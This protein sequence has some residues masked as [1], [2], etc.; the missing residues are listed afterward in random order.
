[1]AI[2]DVN[3][4]GVSSITARRRNWVLA[5]LFAV[6]ALNLFDRQIINVLAQDI[7]A[8]LGISDTQLGLLTGTAFGIFYSVLALPLGRLADRV[9]RVKLIAAVV[10]LWSGCTALCG[11]AG[12]YL[13]L[14]LMRM[15][16]SIGEAGSQ[17]ASTALIPDFFPDER[18]TTAV[19][20]M[21]SS[22]SV[23]SFLGL[24]VG[25][26]VGSIWGWRTAFVVAGI[27]GF[28]L[29]AVMLA[30]MRDPRSAP[31]VERTIHKTSM[32]DALRKLA[33]RP[34]LR[35]LTA[36]LACSLIILYG[37][38]AWLPPFFIRVH[39]MTTAQIGGFAGL[40]VGLGGAI[41]SIGCGFA[42][43]LVRSRVRHVESKALMIALALTIPTLLV[44]VLSA[45]R[46]IALWSMFLLNIFVFA[47]VGPMV[48]LIQN[49]VSAD[50]RG[51]AI[52]A[53]I[54]F[55]NILS[56]AA[57]LPLIG[58][59]SDTLKPAYGVP[60][61]GYALALCA[62][63]AALAGIFAHWRVFRSLRAGG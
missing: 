13:Q 52:A 44:T 16:V 35:W 33:G 17:P 29:A 23:G 6:G 9:D 60:A 48:M 25:G 46:T 36:A 57:G 14:F 21:I 28:F 38:G 49:E 18:R 32:F 63:T 19:G 54:S 43:D 5:L 2:V 10:V 30:T 7:K 50:M 51:L 3:Q 41:G 24:V 20:V 55:S 53:A 37:S 42:C 59:I 61:I 1:M 8:E 58:L 26:Y 4:V 12:N 34:R 11:L 45:D 40:A 22:A 56:L 39:G 62:I 27:P 47:Y 31:G 15:G